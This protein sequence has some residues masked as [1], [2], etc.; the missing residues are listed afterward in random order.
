MLDYFTAFLFKAF[1]IDL[2]G[3]TDEKYASIIGAFSLVFFL[4]DTG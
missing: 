1:G 4:V 2:T 3:G